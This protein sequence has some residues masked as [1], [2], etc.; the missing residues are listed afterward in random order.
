MIEILRGRGFEADRR[1]ANLGHNP[2]R[3]TFLARP[4]R[5]D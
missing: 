5:E 3:M 2:K 4:V 1:D